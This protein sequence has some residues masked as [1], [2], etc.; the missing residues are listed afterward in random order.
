MKIRCTESTNLNLHTPYDTTPPVQYTAGSL[1]GLL[2]LL[3]YLRPEAE[4]THAMAFSGF[5][6]AW[7][8]RFSLGLVFFFHT[9]QT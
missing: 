6:N 3:N 9:L 4:G 8:W 5:N 7:S 2:L 1:S